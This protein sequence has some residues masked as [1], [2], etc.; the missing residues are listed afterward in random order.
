MA[1]A[2][3][4]ASVLQNIAPLQAATRLI[5]AAVVL[6]LIAAFIALYILA[7][8]TDQT[9]AE[10]EATFDE[11]PGDVAV[12]GIDGLAGEDLVPGA[13]NFDAHARLSANVGTKARETRCDDT[14]IRPPGSPGQGGHLDADRAFG[15]RHRVHG[16]AQQCSVGG[17]GGPDAVG[18]FGN[19]FQHAKLIAVGCIGFPPADALT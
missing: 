15:R 5:A 17:L 3:V 9:F 19:G 14:F 8:H 16:G 6:I 2:V 12:V 10:W 11:A 18:G 13:E 1:A 7:D 4:G